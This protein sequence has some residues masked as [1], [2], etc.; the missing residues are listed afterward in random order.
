MLFQSVC[1]I[2]ISMIKKQCGN[3]N[4]TYILEKL[5]KLFQN[6]FTLPCITLDNEQNNFLVTYDF[7]VAF[8]F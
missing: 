2:T 6:W 4:H 1:H 5:I 8:I 3:S 7:G